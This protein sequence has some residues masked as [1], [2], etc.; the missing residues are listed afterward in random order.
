V[1]VDVQ[2]VAPIELLVAGGNR[3]L[4]QIVDLR[5]VGR[6][7]IRS[8]DGVSSLRGDLT[9]GARELLDGVDRGVTGR[10]DVQGIAG[11][12]I[13]LLR[14]TG[15]SLEIENMA[16]GERILRRFTDALAAG[17]LLFQRGLDGALLVQD[18]LHDIYE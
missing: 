15:R 2:N 6:G 1:P 16:G 4:E 10:A 3:L 5:G 8:R 13:I 11:V 17:N 9:R 14:L 7:R 18:G 12:L